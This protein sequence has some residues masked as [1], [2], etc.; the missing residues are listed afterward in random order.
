M[1]EGHPVGCVLNDESKLRLQKLQ[2]WMKERHAEENAAGRFGF[3]K[4]EEE[5]MESLV[6][7]SKQKPAIEALV[8]AR[9]DFYRFFTAHD[10]RR[11][12]NF[13]KT[14]PEMRDFWKL[15]QTEALRVILNHA[16]SADSVVPAPE[17][18][19]GI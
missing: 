12:T 14:F 8:Q 13:E 2:W 6:A 10:L 9:A 5:R 11:A 7:W 3:L 15:C 17:I 16:D 19:A 1:G 18:D 4:I